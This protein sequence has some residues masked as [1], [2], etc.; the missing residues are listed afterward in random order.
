MSIYFLSFLELTNNA[1]SLKV[2][3]MKKALLLS[4]LALT[5][6]GF[7]PMYGSHSQSAGLSTEAAQQMADIQIDYI[8]DREGQF[9][10]NELIDNLYP[11][12]E[13]HN[14]RYQLTFSELQT[15]IRE[16]DLTKSSEATRSQVISHVTFTLVDRENG[17]VLM[18]RPARSI[19]SYNV[20]PSEFATNVTE[21]NARES[22]LR[23]IARQI[24]LQL[25]LYFNRERVT[26]NEAAN[27]AN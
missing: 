3:T 14:A 4:V 12:G 27:T 13:P 11:Q 26:P 1:H 6:C 23:D 5:A 20:L 21:D 8:P 25:S 22:A 16:L 2:K 19:S 15:T 7:Q 9:L 17:E 10:R 18:S 24:G